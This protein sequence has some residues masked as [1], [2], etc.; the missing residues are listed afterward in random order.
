ME[1]VIYQATDLKDRR[2]E[3]LSAAASGRALVR[4]VDGTALVF[5]RLEQVEAD[6]FVAEWSLAL[7]QAGEDRL[8]PRLRWL[9][10]LDTDDRA[11]CLGDLWE[12]L[13]DLSAGA[14]GRETFE[15]ALAEWRATAQSLAD[16]DR[17]DILLGEITD[18]DFVPADPPR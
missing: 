17:R 2:T 14:S 13:E 3:L 1:S 6:R 12:A 18:D 7:H 16:P 9:R 8:P 5:T 15:V 4:A 11:E 10:H